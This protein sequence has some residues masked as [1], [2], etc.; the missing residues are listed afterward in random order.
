ME[1]KRMG[2]NICLNLS[3]IFVRKIFLFDKHSKSAQKHV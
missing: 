2:Y 1:K 3:P